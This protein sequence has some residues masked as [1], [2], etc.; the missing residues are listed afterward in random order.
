MKNNTTFDEKK[1]CIDGMVQRNAFMHEMA[2]TNGRIALVDNDI[3]TVKVGMDKLADWKAKGQKTKP[4][5][6][7]ASF[8]VSGNE[9]ATWKIWLCHFEKEKASLENYKK[10]NNLISIFNKIE[11]SFLQGSD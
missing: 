1:E 6:K 8:P 4:P 10:C 3:Q 11:K 9:R 2:Y 5:P 7:T